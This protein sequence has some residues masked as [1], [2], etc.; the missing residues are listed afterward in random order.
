M[1]LW[2]LAVVEG[3]GLALGG[4][5]WGATCW[6]CPK[7]HGCQRLGLQV[8]QQEGSQRDTHCADPTC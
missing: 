5:R 8:K 1:L 3:C 4:L 6:S 2:W 7:L